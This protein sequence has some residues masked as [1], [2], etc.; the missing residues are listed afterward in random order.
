MILGTA[1][2]MSP[3]QARGKAVDKRADIWAFGVLFLEMLSGRRLFDGETAS[4]V[5]AAVLRQEVDWAWLPAVT[6]PRV[7]ELLRRC[8]AKDVKERLQ[9]IGEARITLAHVADGASDGFPTVGSLTLE[10]RGVG[11]TWAWTLAALALV[12]WIVTTVAFGRRG[13]D[14]PSQMRTSLALPEGLGI[15]IATYNDSQSLATLTVSPKGDQMAFVGFQEG[16]GALYLR[17]FDSF[18]SVRLTKTEGATGPFFSP[19]GTRLAFFARERLWRIDLPGGVPVDLAPAATSSVGGS[20]GDD[21]QIV[22]APS[23]AETLWTI[24]A[25]GGTPRPLTK[26]DGAA[27][28]LSHRWP[29][30]LPGSAS[31]LFA[32]KLS[33]NETLDDAHIAV[34]DVKTGAHRVLVEGGSMPR[35]L[36]GGR[37]VFARAGKLYAVPFDL[38]SRSIHGAPVPVL[39]GVATVPNNGAA[40][41]D[42]TRAGM[43]AYATGG[44]IKQTGHFSWEG[45]GRPARVLDRLDVAL[46]GRVRLSRDARR[47]IVPVAA[48]NDKLWLIDLEQMNATRLTSGG[49]NDAEGVLSPD[50]RFVLFPSDRAGGGYRFYRMPLNGS[51]PPS[52]L[53]EGNGRIHSISY[54]ARMM[55][56][57]LDSAQ[58][59]RDAYV[60][61]LAE[62]G[63]LAGKPIRVAG[64]GGDQDSPTVSADGALVAYESSESGRPE[65]YVARLADP[66]SKRRVT[67][68]SGWSPLWS[69]DGKR[70]LYLSDDRVFSVALRS[71]SDLRFDEPQAMTASNV[72]GTINSFDVSADGTSVL[73]G[74]VADP[75]MLRRDI[76]LW[77]AWG[78]TLPP[79]Q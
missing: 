2:Y 19:D 64:G 42:V 44:R 18:D 9:A 74:R 58:D 56:F 38:A 27:G 51:A 10:R 22:Y 24:P 49:G 39:D 3:E 46:F 26:I 52:V 23:Y 34:A 77:P 21:G 70:L 57:S 50:G 72:P 53:L 35:Y 36:D 54:L 47:A 69:R 7:R 45:P 71:A 41:Y 67:N 29:C 4:D 28:E 43:L 40:W 78:K 30:V 68:N 65:I 63:T 6:P 33:S 62:D 61:A 14:P 12:G 37:L 8:L 76:R 20:W 48:A 11:S 73:V 17:R 79:V 5:L 15:P 75:L 25:E 16:Q 66:G 55:G 60:V 13:P 31:V 1:A 32:I 59:G